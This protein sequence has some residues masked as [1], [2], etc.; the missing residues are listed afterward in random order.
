MNGSA[1][2]SG[3][4]GGRG[5]RP[6][7]P[8]GERGGARRLLPVK[9]SGRLPVERSGGPQ[10]APL[11]RRMILAMIGQRLPSL[12]LSKKELSIKPVP[13]GGSGGVCISRILGRRKLHSRRRIPGISRR[14]PSA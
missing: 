13:L 10:A 7:V 9:A 3:R 4:G 14:S 5:R 12:S 8:K 11:S 1:V 6:R 2:R